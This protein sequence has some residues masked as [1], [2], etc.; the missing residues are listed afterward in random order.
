MFEEGTKV[1]YESMEG[2]IDFVGDNYVV[3]ELKKSQN[4]SPARLLVYR[5]NYKLIQVCQF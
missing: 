4:R 2:V 1:S 3:I 5:H